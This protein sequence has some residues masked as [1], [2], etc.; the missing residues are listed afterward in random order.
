MAPAFHFRSVTFRRQHDRPLHRLVDFLV[1]VGPVQ[2]SGHGPPTTPVQPWICA[3]SSSPVTVRVHDGDNCCSHAPACCPL[4]GSDHFLSVGTNSFPCL[5]VSDAPRGPL[6]RDRR[7]TSLRAFSQLFLWAEKILQQYSCEQQ[8]Q[9]VV[10]TSILDGLY[11]EMLSFLTTHA[12]GQRHR[13][14][15]RRQPAW[16]DVDCL[17]ACGCT[18]MVP[19]RTITG[20]VLRSLYMRF[21][22]ARQQ[23]IAQSVQP[24]GISGL[25]GKIMS[26]L[27]QLTIHGLPH[28]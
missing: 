12:P 2:P 27:F 11:T 24:D 19:F 18:E 3:L 7:A 17:A 20:C 22:A 26:P 6:L 10:R 16:W 4:M 21:S 15:R 28:L 5:E 1:W 8:P 9:E 25:S 23:F 14:H 13:S